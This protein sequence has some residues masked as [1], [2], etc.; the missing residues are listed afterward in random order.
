MGAG[1][2]KLYL[3]KILE[4]RRAVQRLSR[5]G[6][7]DVY[8][9]VMPFLRLAGPA[10]HMGRLAGVVHR[11]VTALLALTSCLGYLV[12]SGG[13]RTAL[14]FAGAALLLFA[15]VLYNF[16]GTGIC[17]TSSCWL[18][19]QNFTV[20][21]PVQCKGVFPEV[22]NKLIGDL[23]KEK[24]TLQILDVSTGSCNSLYRHGWMKLKAEYTGLDLSETMLL[25][26]LHLWLRNKFRLISFS[27]P[28]RSCHSSRASFDVVLNYGALNG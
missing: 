18:S 5:N 26:G 28:P 9:H 20:V 14:W 23:L 1:I 24:G 6:F 27:V 16:S 10:R 21:K 11:P 19:G 13:W 7:L 25:Q 2:P 12:L 17:F 4:P 8:G 22:H 15:W 3:E